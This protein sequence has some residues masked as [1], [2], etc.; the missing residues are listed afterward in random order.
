MNLRAKAG[1]VTAIGRLAVT[2]P[3][4]AEACTPGQHGQNGRQDQ[5]GQVK[6]QQGSGS[7]HGQFARFGRRGRIFGQSEFGTLVSWNAIQTGTNTYSG[8]ITVSKP[9]F[10]AHWARNGS[11]TQPS[12]STQPAQVTYTFT[13]AK[14]FFGQGVTQPPAGDLVKVIGAR[15]GQDGHLVSFEARAGRLRINPGR[16][17]S[18]AEPLLPPASRTRT[19]RARRSIPRRS[20]R[21]SVEQVAA[22]R[23]RFEVRVDTRQRHTRVGDD[24]IEVRHEIGLGHRRQLAQGLGI[25]AIRVDSRQSRAMPGRPTHGVPDEAAQ[26]GSRY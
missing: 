15:L 18:A 1:I 6:D 13:N 25:E 26:P 7:D 10:T 17:Q 11:S 3:A 5:Q 24:L 23:D 21:C 22:R 2:G 9:A 19:H 4:V 14:V 12:Q 20:A 8:S 16:V